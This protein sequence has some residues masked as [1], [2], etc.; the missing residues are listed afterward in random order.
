VSLPS[1]CGRLRSFPFVRAAADEDRDDALLSDSSQLTPDDENRDDHGAEMDERRLRR[2]S[3]A[4]DR[5]C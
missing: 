2:L 4:C 5:G 1:R 3:S